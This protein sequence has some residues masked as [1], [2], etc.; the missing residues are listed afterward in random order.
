M[1][2]HID[3]SFSLRTAVETAASELVTVQQWG[4]SSLITLPLIYPSGTHVAVKIALVADGLRISDNGFAYREIEAIG[5][6]KSFK[7]VAG[8]IAE[9]AE[10]NR[11]ARVLYVD[12]PPEQLTR[13]ICDVGLA[14]WQVVDRVYSRHTALSDEAEIYLQERLG[15]L[16]GPDRLRRDNVITGASNNEW[17][18]TAVVESD[19]RIAVFHAVS[20][21]SAAIYRTVAAFHDLA[22]LDTP[23][24][25]IAVVENKQSLGATQLNILSQAG[26]V[27]ERTQ[28]D[29][30]FL[31]AAA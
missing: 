31:R 8:P 1:V 26:R 12:V 10:L 16:F 24:I 17:K 6:E 29:E 2:T 28:P 19:D 22:Y 4:D 27:L 15:R 3:S 11:N 7:R 25:R 13:A 14:S 20:D 23:P 18:F 21:H 30:V 9:A 5:A